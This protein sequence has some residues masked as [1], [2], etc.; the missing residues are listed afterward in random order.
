MDSRYLS[1]PVGS[2]RVLDVLHV[3]AEPGE[4]QTRGGEVLV[5]GLN[6]WTK[7]LYVQ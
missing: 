6:S 4:S 1:Q 7:R 5:L 2:I 3:F